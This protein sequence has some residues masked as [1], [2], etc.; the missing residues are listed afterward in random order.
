M[1][2]KNGL[3]KLS[4]PQTKKSGKYLVLFVSPKLSHDSQKTKQLDKSSIPSLRNVPRRENYA[5]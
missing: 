5:G 1:G 3:D 4:K 2:E